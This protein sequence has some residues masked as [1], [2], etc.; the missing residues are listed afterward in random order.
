MNT[1]KT[2]RQPYFLLLAALL[3]AASFSL[4]KSAKSSEA[5]Y[6]VIKPSISKEVLNTVANRLKEKNIRVTYQ[7]LIFKSGQLMSIKA[8]IEVATPGKP[9]RTYALEETSQA[10]SFKP[11]VFYSLSDGERTGFVKGVGEDMTRSE[12]RIVNENLVGLLIEGSG[13]RE[14]IGS[15][16]SN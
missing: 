8:R 4:G 9:I 5:I 3:A 2:I 7:Q 16:Q 10:E 12:K 15:W 6:F 11:L 13:S 1:A 14:V